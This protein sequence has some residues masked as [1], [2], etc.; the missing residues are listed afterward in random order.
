MKPRAGK[1]GFI[2]FGIL[3]VAAVVVGILH[4]PILAALGV[5]VFALRGL[6]AFTALPVAGLSGVPLAIFMV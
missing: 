6:L 3:S 1:A 4:I 2:L 5:D